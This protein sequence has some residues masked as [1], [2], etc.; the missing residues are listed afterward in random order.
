MSLCHLHRLRVKS[1]HL[2]IPPQVGSILLSKTTLE[3]DDKVVLDVFLSFLVETP[4]CSKSEGITSVRPFCNDWFSQN[5]IVQVAK[6]EEVTLLLS[7]LSL[8]L[9]PTW[10][11]LIKLALLTLS[12][13]GGVNGWLSW[14]LIYFWHDMNKH[15]WSCRRRWGSFFKGH[16][17]CRCEG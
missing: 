17:S 5:F 13:E 8:R 16:G 4:N 6:F 14:G 11:N 9:P 2:L 15:L 12:F 3:M 1:L 7:A 10:Y